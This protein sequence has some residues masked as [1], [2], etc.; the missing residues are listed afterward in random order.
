MWPPGAFVTYPL[1]W[2][3]GCHFVALNRVSNEGISSSFRP[4]PESA[5]SSIVGTGAGD[6][7]AGGVAF[8]GGLRTPAI[9]DAFGTSLSHGVD[10]FAF[11]GGLVFEGLSLVCRHVTLQFKSLRLWQSRSAS[12][13]TRGGA[14]TG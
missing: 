12:S 9:E 1:Q 4:N 13:S 7:S 14:S 8:E 2:T 10:P 11:T 6:E 3:V 5:E